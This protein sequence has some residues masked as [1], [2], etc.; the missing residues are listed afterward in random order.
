MIATQFYLAGASGLVYV[1]TDDGNV[2][3]YKNCR[4]F[5]DHEYPIL[6]NNKDVLSVMLVDARDWTNQKEYRPED[7]DGGDGDGGD[8]DGGNGDGEIGDEENGIERNGNGSNGS[9]GSGPETGGNG[10][11]PGGIAGSSVVTTGVTVGETGVL[12]AIPP[13]LASQGDNKQKEQ[14]PRL[15]PLDPNAKASIM[16]DPTSPITYTPPSA[17]FFAIPDLG[18]W[19]EG[20]SGPDSSTKDKENLESTNLFPRRQRELRP[21]L[22]GSCRVRLP[23]QL[24]APQASNS[25]GGTSSNPTLA[26]QPQIDGLI[27]KLNAVAPGIAEIGSVLV[28]QRAKAPPSNRYVLDI[29]ILDADGNMINNMVNVEAPPSDQ[30][31]EIQIPAGVQL[32]QDAPTVKGPS[33]PP[34]YLSVDDDPEAP[35]RFRYGDY[36]LVNFKPGLGL[37]FDSNNQDP[38]HQCVISAW[39]NSERQIKCF[40][41]VVHL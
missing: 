3:G 34:P 15:K 7:G 21:R 4:Y 30:E 33:S 32:G 1:V 5:V 29:S 22:D 36:A 14:D 26:Q 27:P 37:E 39:I 18:L 6:A 10:L 9:G 23:D 12:Q 19:T 31:I 20:S 35:L 41:T 16:P 40:F 13:A 38:E 11:N 2:P 24:D 8:R 17:D 28:T 25:A